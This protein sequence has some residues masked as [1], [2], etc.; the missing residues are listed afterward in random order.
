M[1]AKPAGNGRPIKQVEL[2]RRAGITQPSVSDFVTGKRVLRLLVDLKQ[3]LGKTVVLI[4]HNGAI[5][6]VADRVVRLR[7]GRVVDQAAVPEDAG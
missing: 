3:R 2:A 4:T 7:D 6:P 5:A 1:G